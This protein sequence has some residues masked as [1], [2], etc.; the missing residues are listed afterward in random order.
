MICYTVY[1]ES[2]IQCLYKTSGIISYSRNLWFNLQYTCNK[3][4]DKCNYLL[5]LD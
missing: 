1:S 5:H 2:K 4:I 3:S